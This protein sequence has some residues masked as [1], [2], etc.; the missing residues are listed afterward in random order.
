MCSLG[1]NSE[2]KLPVSRNEWRRTI[3]WG[4]TQSTNKAVLG[5]KTGNAFRIPRD[6]KHPSYPAR[7]ASYSAP[8]QSFVDADPLVIRS[9]LCY[10]GCFCFFLFFFGFCGPAAGVFPSEECL[11]GGPFCW[12]AA[13]VFP[14]VECLFGGPFCG[15]AAGVFPSVECLFFG[16]F[17]GPAAGTYCTGFIRL[18][19]VSM[20]KAPNSRAQPVQNRSHGCKKA[21][22]M[23]K[24]PNVF[25]NQNYSCKYL[26]KEDMPF[27]AWGSGSGFTVN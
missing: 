27:W 20:I 12:P 7:L 25:S 26:G 17:C 11:L 24:E 6:P 3:H 2:T 9:T 19:L 8:C 14:S 18:P 16:P 4:R 13:G 21:M 15:P 22:A 23:I 5:S 1:N 10:D